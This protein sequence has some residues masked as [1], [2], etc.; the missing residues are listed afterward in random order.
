M[1]K[2]RCSECARLLDRYHEAAKALGE[3][4]KEFGE[5]ALTKKTEMLRHLDKCNLAL[6]EFREHRRTVHAAGDESLNV[7]CIIGVGAKFLLPLLRALS[8]SLGVLTL[9]HVAAAMGW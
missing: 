4:K 8:F 6:E 3:M 7:L 5:S 2:L 9:A 1:E